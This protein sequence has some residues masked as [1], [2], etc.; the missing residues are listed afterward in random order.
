MHLTDPR[1]AWSRVVTAAGIPNLT[2]DDVYKFMVRHLV[3]AGDKEDLRN[4]MNELLSDLF[5]VQ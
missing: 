1:L 2:M 5:E 3:W 4:N